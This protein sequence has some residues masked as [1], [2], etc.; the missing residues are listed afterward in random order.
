MNFCDWYMN[1]TMAETAPVVVIDKIVADYR[2]HPLNMH[3]TKVHDGTGE[4]ATLQVLERFLYN[5]P[6]STELS[7]RA[8]AIMAL[9]H[10]DWGNKY[11]GASMDADALR[12]YRTALNFD[13]A[14][15]WKGHFLHRYI[16]LLV[17]RTIYERVKCM[18]QR[19]APFRLGT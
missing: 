18:A 14:Q 3:A 2:V 15:C 12:C 6:R 19:L 13:P 5:S 11:F 4:R 16:G 1:L 9:H 8:S 10:A 17:G 7:P